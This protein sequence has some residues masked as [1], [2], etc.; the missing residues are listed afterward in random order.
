[1]DTQPSPSE[2][3]DLPGASGPT[4]P[5]TARLVGLLLTALGGLLMCVGALMPWVRTSLEGAPADFS[6]TYFGIDIPDGKVVLVLG[7]IIIAALIV[8]RLSKAASL[9]RSASLVI[10]VAAFAGVGITTVTLITADSRFHDSAVDD[11]I[12]Q[13]DSPTDEMRAQADELIDLQLAS[14][15]FAAIGGGILAV[16]GG[17]FTLAWA[18]ARAREPDLPS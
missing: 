13:I 9:A 6:P 10:I 15:P 8:S 17:A 3:V 7:V 11:I 12:E 1:M 16:V 14:G 2:G 4:P 5:A 18:N